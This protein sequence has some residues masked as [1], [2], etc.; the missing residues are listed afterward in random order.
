MGGS[1]RRDLIVALVAGLLAVGV[2]ATAPAATAAEG[3]T[4]S[5]GDQSGLERD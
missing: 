3:L 4:L 5:V 1:R 2:T